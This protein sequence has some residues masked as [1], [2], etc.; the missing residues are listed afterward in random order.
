[1]GGGAGLVCGL[2][3]EAGSMLFLFKPCFTEGMP[4][5]SPHRISLAIFSNTVNC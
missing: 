3:K 1:M 4:F 5:F 2:Q